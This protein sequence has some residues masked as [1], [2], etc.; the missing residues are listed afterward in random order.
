MEIIDRFSTFVNLKYL[1]LRIE[2]LT[3]NDNMLSSA[4]KIEEILPSFI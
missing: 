4:P 3:S 1:P 2:Q